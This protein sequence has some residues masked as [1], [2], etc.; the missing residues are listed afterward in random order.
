MP[1]NELLTP[2]ALKNESVVYSKEHDYQ[3]YINQIN[4]FLQHSIILERH[5]LIFVCTLIQTLVSTV[6]F[7]LFCLKGKPFWIALIFSIIMILLTGF[8]WNRFI[9]IIQKY[10]KTESDKIKALRESN[11]QC[12]SCKANNIIVVSLNADNKFNCKTCGQKN[13]IMLTHI[14]EKLNVSI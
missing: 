9:E 12:A 14:V 10:R 3:Q 8:L 6:C 5:V 7:L 4:N 2:T 11:I 13:N 1:T